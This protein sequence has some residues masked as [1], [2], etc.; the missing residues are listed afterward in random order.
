MY[1]TLCTA[2]CVQHI[3]YSTLCTAHCVQHDKS[4]LRVSLTHIITPS[5]LHVY[6][7]IYIYIEREREIDYIFGQSTEAQF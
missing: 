1:S 2:H 3:M 6:V 4:L 5:A 7:Y